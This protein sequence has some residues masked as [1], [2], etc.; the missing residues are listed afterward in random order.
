MSVI[1]NFRERH[2]H[3]NLRPSDKELKYFWF[4]KLSNY[5]LNVLPQTYVTPY[6]AHKFGSPCSQLINFTKLRQAKILKK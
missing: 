4:I 3:L 1:L 2:P 5:I 6:F